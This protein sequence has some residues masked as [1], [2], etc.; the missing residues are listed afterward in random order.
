MKYLHAHPTRYV[1]G[2]LAAVVVAFALVAGCSD[3]GETPTAPDQSS[4]Q[5]VFSRSHPRIQAAAAV[6]ELH[7]RK[8]IDDP[9]IVGSAV[10]LTEEGEPAILVLLESE[11]G[12]KKIEDSIDGI[13]VVKIVTG[14]IKALGKPPKPPKPEKP[15]HKARQT[16][17]IPLGVSGG[18]AWDLANGYCCSGTLGAL[19]SGGSK[20]FILSNSHVF[21]GDIAP[22]DVAEIGDPINQPGLIDVACADITED[23]V[24]Y[25]SSGSSL[26]GNSNVDCAKAEIISGRVKTDGE[27]LGIGTLSSQTAD[28][29]IGQAVKKSGRTTGVTRSTVTGL[30]ANVEV[31]YEDECAG[32][33]FTVEY[34]GQILV[35]SK[36]DKFL[37]GGDSGSLMV[38]DV[39]TNPRAVGL[40]YAGGGGTAVANPIGDV[41]SYLNV[42]MVGN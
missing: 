9:G 6:Q 11:R 34:T 30:N 32:E 14:R 36:G 29:F 33:Y 15:D 1:L 16:R 38:E 13:P 27:I 8:L 18:N 5:I 10:G 20:L 42:T 26:T 37:K 3:M 24:A 28:A 23:Y 40:L 39:D 25:L 4:R 35:K 12:G 19:V 22:P 41:L 17:P 7:A 21:A 2:L 31:W